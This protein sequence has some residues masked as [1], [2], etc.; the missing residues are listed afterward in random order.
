[1]FRL[2]MQYPK[3]GRRPVAGIMLEGVH[4]MAHRIFAAATVAMLGVLCVSCGGTAQGLASASGKVVCNGEP[5]AG[6][7]LVFHRLSGGEAPP[8]DAANIIPSAIVGADGGYTVESQPLGYGIAPGKYA[9]LVEW[10]QESDPAV[11]T[12]KSSKAPAGRGKSVTVTKRSKFDPV[13]VDR[14]KGRYMDK[15]KPAF[16]REIKS[17]G[18]NDLGTIEL[19][20]K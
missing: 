11:S 16:E 4:P 15:S 13:P 17:G 6:A 20:M 12:S 5:A 14:L 8:A 3:T 2:R 1:M 9:V 7:F 18:S 10:S 19:E